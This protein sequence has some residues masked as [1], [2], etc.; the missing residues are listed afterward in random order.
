MNCA[1]EADRQALDDLFGRAL[2]H[3]DLCGDL[4]VRERRGH[5]LARLP[6]AAS[7]VSSVMSLSDMPEIGDLATEIY[8]TIFIP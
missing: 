2:L 5:V 8:R 6:L 1:S 7:T 4:L 3:E